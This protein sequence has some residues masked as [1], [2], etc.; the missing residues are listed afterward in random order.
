MV[1]LLQPAR[2]LPGL[3]IARKTLLL[4]PNCA[5]QRSTN[6]KPGLVS[7]AIL[8][9]Q[10][11]SLRKSNP[12]TAHPVDVGAFLDTTPRTGIVRMRAVPEFWP[13][14]PSHTNG[15]RGWPWAP[16]PWSPAMVACR[17]RFWEDGP[18]MEGARIQPPRAMVPCT[19]RRN[20]DSISRHATTEKMEE[21][22]TEPG[23]RVHLQTV[24]PNCR[25]ASNFRE[26]AYVMLYQAADHSS[27]N[28]SDQQ[29]QRPRSAR[30]A[31]SI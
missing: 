14:L 29:T 5:G 26:A 6:A 3:S 22:R 18:K 21:S 4:N 2:V 19:V 16:K 30:S 10:L 28:Q 12:L 1:D 9:C 27:P 20:M 24:V 8:G 13:L 25:D 7:T 15:I 17:P 11:V 23:V 31:A